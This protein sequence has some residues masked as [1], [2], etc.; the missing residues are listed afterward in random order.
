MVRA[1]KGGVGM[2]DAIKVLDERSKK[3]TRRQG[4][5]KKDRIEAANQ[6]LKG[7]K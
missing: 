2:E 7:K 1:V 3:V 4:D 5:D 6:I